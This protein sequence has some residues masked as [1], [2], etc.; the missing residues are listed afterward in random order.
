MTK[1]EN[2]RRKFDAYNNSDVSREDLHTGNELSSDSESPP[3]KRAKTLQKVETSLTEMNR[4]LKVFSK[5]W[6]EVVNL[7]MLAF[8]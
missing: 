8:L 6:Y 7:K 4:M 1:D 2:E 5:F 3:A